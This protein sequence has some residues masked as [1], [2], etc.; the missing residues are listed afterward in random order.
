MTVLIL[1]PL[2]LEFDAVV[3]HVKNRTAEIKQ[4]ATYE[5]GTFTGKQHTYEVVICEPGMKNVDMALATEK[6]IQI[7]QPQIVLLVGIA[8]GVKDVHIGDVLIAK[9]VYGYESGKEDADEYR[10]R[11]SVESFSADLLAYAQALSRKPD[12]KQR[13]HD[14]A[15]DARIFMGPIAAGDKVVAG[16]SN[17]TFQRIKEH[18]N[19]TLGLE[20]EAIGFATALQ[21]YRHIHGLAIRGI[22]D[23]CE[24]K[25]ETDKQN[26]QPVAAERAAA[27]AFELLYELDP[28]NFIS[29]PMDA[30]TLAKD[31]YSLLFASAD[32]MKGIQNDF[33]NAASKEVREIWKH[34]KPLL[35]EQIADLE[36]DPTDDAAQG[37]VKMKLKKE[38]ERNETMLQELT[39]LLEKAKSAPAA[40]GSI[41]N[42]KNVIQGGNINVSGDFRL[43]DG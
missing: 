41:I 18:F 39:A 40:P 6:A 29:P 34:I 4:A 12:W 24:G 37:A 30:K 22:S 8:G 43:G 25:S 9:K 19:D 38:L 20:M 14:Q 2:P 26:W 11:P 16:T 28:S 13:T 31:V 15:P 21:K 32:S 33:A 36:E 17:P 10:S 7:F 1:T 23:L 5:R 35:A 42:S 27:V 3:R